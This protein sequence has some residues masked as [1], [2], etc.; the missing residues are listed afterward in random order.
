MTLFGMGRDG[1]RAMYHQIKKSEFSCVKELI[2]REDG[3]LDF[4]PY[5]PN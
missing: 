5:D 2:E 4:G 1:S 3:G